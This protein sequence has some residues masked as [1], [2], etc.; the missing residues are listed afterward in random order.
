MKIYVKQ[1]RLYVAARRKHRGGSVTSSLSEISTDP[2]GKVGGC[3]VGGRGGGVTSPAPPLP[4]QNASGL[5]FIVQRRRERFFLHLGYLHHGWGHG[6]INYID[7]K[8]NVV[9]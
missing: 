5:M 3:E 9:I 8:Q 1:G 2:L 4:L 6:L 7:T